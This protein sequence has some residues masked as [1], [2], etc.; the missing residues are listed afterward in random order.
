MHFLRIKLATR[1]HLAAPLW[2]YQLGFFLLPAGA[3]YM[4]PPFRMF[5]PPRFGSISFQ[6]RQLRK[7][8][9]RQHNT[10]EA[11]AETWCGSGRGHSRLSQTCTNMVA[12]L[13]MS[14]RSSNNVGDKYAK[15][16]QSILGEPLGSRQRPQ[17]R[18]WSKL[19]SGKARLP[20]VTLPKRKV[21]RQMQIWDRPGANFNANST[22]HLPKPFGGP[23][24]T[25]G[26]RF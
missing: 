14:Y 3:P 24:K 18:V 11:Q 1:T 13:A 8:A 9:S 17:C 26:T 23:N 7:N 16:Q 21:L 19:W 20:R 25:D 6:K 15:K 12:V 4:A 2:P 5:G 22:A 10:A